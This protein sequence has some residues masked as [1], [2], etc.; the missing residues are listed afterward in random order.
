MLSLKRALYD[1]GLS[2]LADTSSFMLE[3]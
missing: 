2:G 3:P 1:S